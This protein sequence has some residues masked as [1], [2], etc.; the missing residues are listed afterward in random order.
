MKKIES[1]R[2]V[3]IRYRAKCPV[4]GYL[5]IENPSVYDLSWRLGYVEYKCQGCQGIVTIPI[6]SLVMDKTNNTKD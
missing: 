6:N 4:C 3:V 5:T 2:E 1:V